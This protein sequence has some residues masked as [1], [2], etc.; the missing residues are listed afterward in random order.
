MSTISIRGTTGGGLCGF[1]PTPVEKKCVHN[2]VLVNATARPPSDSE[3]S[4]S[5]L[6]RKVLFDKIKGSCDTAI[7]ALRRSSSSFTCLIPMPS[8]LIFP[9]LQF[10]K[11]QECQEQRAFTAIY[12]VSISDVKSLDAALQWGKPYLPVR[13]QTIRF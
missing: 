3:P 1:T 10:Q 5:K 13:P 9:R 6:K 12:K 8:S 11:P 2:S 7:K 4:G